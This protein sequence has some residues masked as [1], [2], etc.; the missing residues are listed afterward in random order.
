MD[1]TCSTT[2]VS[3]ARIIDRISKDAICGL[4]YTVLARRTGESREVAAGIEMALLPWMEINQIDMADLGA[5]R[6]GMN[7]D[8]FRRSTNIE[9]RRGLSPED[10][11][12]AKTPPVAPLPP[13]TRTP[14]DL[15]SQ[16]GLDDIK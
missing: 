4:G 15:S 5:V 13:L 16:A 7:T 14:G 11:L 2:A 9:D 10:S 12:R 8:G 6:G 3:S 1:P